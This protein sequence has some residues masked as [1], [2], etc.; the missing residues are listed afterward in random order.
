MPAFVCLASISLDHR[1]GVFIEE[2]LSV[3]QHAAGV[4]KEGDQ[5][6]LSP[7]PVCSGHMRAEHRIGLPQ[8][9]GMC[10]AEGESTPVFADVFFE[11]LVFSHHATEGGE[12]DLV[13]P[14]ESLFDTETVDGRLV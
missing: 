5:L 3:T 10:H 7:R 1:I 9:V 12:C 6:G 13:G 4:V 8:L 11:E 2:E 14:Q